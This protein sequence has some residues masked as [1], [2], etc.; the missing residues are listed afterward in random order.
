MPAAHKLDSAYRTAYTC[1]IRRDT[2]CAYAALRADALDAMQVRGCSASTLPW[3]ATSDAEHAV[4]Y[5]AHGPCSLSAN[6]TRPH[7]T[8]HEEPV[9][10]Y[11]LR[12]AG[13]PSS[14]LP[15]SLSR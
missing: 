10:A 7:V 1:G 8:E 5:E 3:L 2:P 4:S 11:T 13:I 9:D 14:T 12:P 6:E 15:N